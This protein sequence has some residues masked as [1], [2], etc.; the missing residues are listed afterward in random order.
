M[1]FVEC[2]SMPTIVDNIEIRLLDQLR[3]FIG[4]AVRLKACIG[5]LNLKG[6]EMLGE[7]VDRLVPNRDD[8][9]CRILVGMA[10]HEVGIDPSLYTA[11]IVDGN[12]KRLHRRQALENFR[13]QLIRGIPTRAAERALRML[14]RQLQDGFV[15]IRL[16]R[17]PSLHAKLYMIE[18]HDPI[19]PLIGY[20]G[21]SNLTF[22]GLYKQ[23]ELN[24]DV[25]EQDAAQKLDRWFEERWK[26]AIDISAD[27]ADIID[28]SWA[29]E[30][31][32]K[33]ENLP[34]LIYLKVA[35]HLS[36]NAR[37]GE[38]E[39][40]IPSD[41]RSTLL[42]FQIAA[43]QLAAKLVQRYVGVL[44]GD[45]V[46]L[47][48]TLMA[49]A[50]ARVLF[51]A[52][53][54]STL[55]ICP[56]KLK[57]M[58]EYHLDQYLREPAGA[59]ARTVSLGKVLDTLDSLPRF[60][61]LIIDESHNLTNRESERYR[62]IAAYIEQNDPRVI[63]LSATP[64]NKHYTDLANQLRLFL[65]DKQPLPAIPERW[66]SYRK[67]SGQ[68]EHAILAELQAPL[69][70]L[71]AFEQ[72]EFPEDWRNLMRHFMV[73]RTRSFIIR[74]Y[75][76]YD[77]TKGRYYVHMNGKPH[78][79]PKRN[80][81]TITIPASGTLYERLYS[82]EVVE[83]IGSLQLA[84]YGLAQYLDRQRLE[85]ASTEHRVIARNLTRAGK[86]LIG[87]ARTNLFK[88]LESSGYAFI[89]SVKRQKLRNS[90]LLYALNHNYEV[91]IGEQ[92]TATI[93]ID[94]DELD[95]IVID[96]AMDS[97]NVSPERIYQALRDNKDKFHW[98]PAQYFTQ[99]L[100]DALNHDNALLS[101]ILN[102]AKDWT[103][104]DD[105]K[106]QQLLYLVNKQHPF[107]KLLIFTQFADTA[108]YAANYLR[109]HGVLGC[110]LVTS[111]TDNVADIVR[112]FAPRANGGIPPGQTELRVIVT[113]DTLSE[114][115]NLQDCHIVVNFDLPWAIV[116]LIQRAGRVDRIGQ[117]HSTITVY[118]FLPSDGIDNIINLR[119]CLRERLETNHEI[120]GTDEKFF[121]ERTYKA[122]EDLYTEKSHVL[123]LDDDDEDVDLTSQALHVWQSASE[124][125]RQ[126][127]LALPAQ[128][129]AS[130]TN[131]T[132][133]PDGAIIY[134]RVYRGTEVSDR[135]LR[136]DTNG[137]RVE[138]S[139]AMIFDEL[140]CNPDTP[141]RSNPLALELA[142]TAA[143][144]IENESSSL[145]G[146]L[147]PVRS[148][149]HRLYSKLVG[150]TRSDAL[151]LS[152][153]E[154][155]EEFADLLFRYPIFPESQK[156]LRNA[157]S[158]LTVEELISVIE[159]LRAN[160]KFVVVSAEAEPH[161][162]ILTTM[163][164]VR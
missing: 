87:F 82:S 89:E 24:V 30:A 48:K 42:D 16:Y 34:Y 129:Y 28:Q 43:V 63:L 103:P 118:S 121:D 25:V 149:R 36:E 151:P 147:G 29:S 40:S 139:L 136:L 138:Q 7:L 148:L 164:L 131:D 106:L 74:H 119:R 32:Q 157:M 135:L 134:A 2:V 20:V 65:D 23:G 158:L 1:F 10:Q 79:F 115:Q 120:I 95:T 110:E 91:P 111:D 143:R 58:W 107:D 93:S 162:E 38:A 17:Q 125:D 105:P 72:S 145:E 127:A 76:E 108:R 26:D 66:F 52:D 35:Y 156:Q 18:R 46:G 12:Y 96:D 64:F 59:N 86:R 153:R 61:T 124:K 8:P 3:Q 50:L 11:P 70:S 122:L 104:K 68:P 116:R 123:D 21:S 160:D 83:K 15:C 80:P 85:S 146:M 132:T 57:D 117:S 152:T 78:Y 5:F 22:A 159:D 6:W 67:Q 51:E 31:T 73:R 71:V 113:T 39:F 144:I 33:I 112:R 45:V 56:P 44:L 92:D 9:P 49:T 161:I 84:R 77:A 13:Q 163:G 88:R 141:A 47:G 54:S 109:Q 53:R 155:A 100:T 101:E 102:L 19:T 99:H 94:P 81:R 37:L 41:L 98:L 62:A 14:A 97:M 128:V 75:A 150:I 55:V 60:Q 142:C 4:N 154:L 114:G 126:R 130:R 133:R 27:L 90:L 137:N 140:R 69:N